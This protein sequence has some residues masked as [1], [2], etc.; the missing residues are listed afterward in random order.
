MIRN[1]LK[2]AFRN[3]MRQK[4]HAIIN[5]LGLTIGL[6]SCLLISFYV[7]DE[8]SY[9]RYHEKGERI[10]R[11]VMEGEAPTGEKAILTIGPHRLKKAFESHFN[12]I[13]EFVRITQPYQFRVQQGERLFL[14]ERIS[15][16]D[17]NIFRV[18]DFEW[19]AGNPEESLNEPFT[20]VINRST[21]EKYF[22]T[23]DVLNESLTF[24][25]DRGKVDVRVTGIIEDMPH[26]SHFHLDFLA[27]M[28]TAQYTFNARELENWGEMTV[29][30]Y[31]LLPPEISIEQIQQQTR[32]FV[33]NTFG[34]EDAQKMT[35]RYQP[36]FD[37]HL[38]SHS[39]FEFEAGGDYTNVVIFSIVAVFIL[40]IASVNYMNM[41][42]AR[43]IKRSKE[44]GIRKVAGAARRQLIFQFIGEAILLSLVAIGLAI[45]ISELIMPW[46]NQ[47]AGKQLEIQWLNR[48]WILLVIIVIPLLVGFLSGI[49]PALY[50][51]AFRPV[52]VLY[53]SGNISSS[54]SRL[55]K[56]LVTGQFAISIIL[57]I[58]TLT[59]YQQWSYMSKKKL[60]VDPSNVV[61][62]RHPGD[63][64][65]TFKQELLNNPDI[66]SVTA[67]NKRLTSRLSS[68][69]G[70]NAEGLPPDL[71]ERSIKIVTVEY[72]FFE[73]LHNEILKGRSFDKQ[74][75]E[76]EHSTFI[77]NEKAVEE[78]GWEEPIGKWFE[79]STLDPQTNNWKTRRGSVVGMAENFHFE[80]LH[81]KIA[82]VVYF[83]DHYWIGWMA[84]RISTD[85]IPQTMGAIKGVWDELEVDTYY[86]PEFYKEELNALYR[87]ERRFFRLFIIFAFLAIFIACMGIYGLASFTA[88]QRTKEMGIRKTFGASTG[89]I[90]TLVNREFLVLVAISNLIAWPVAWYS[91]RAWLENYPYRI[92]LT[93]WFFII[94][95]LLALAIAQMAVSWQAYRAASVNP[96][97]SLRY[98]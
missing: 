88:E 69:L 54:H 35:Y 70:Y 62:L 64:Y 57:I 15:L 7:I 79:T 8:L 2:I 93:P 51:S 6:T 20:T 37:I 44:V 39:R 82:P 85:N 52:R 56:I 10:Y 55:R 78:I 94:G 5:L 30:N 19:I 66:I 34:S 59:I 47:L 92:E 74:Y 21:A 1:Y 12:Q 9:D 17:K 87:S 97:Q 24:L 16:V 91:M 14:E 90:M 72:D 68:N 86:N 42:T 36:L 89:K 48:W 50:L 23:T 4:S 38:R 98:E 96:A 84:I 31:I 53:G 80:S 18:F 43:S 22:G 75:G 28:E 61:I 67:S 60:G 73:T 81:N 41:A 58:C 3:L 49:Y 76:D 77:L 32:G 27:S 46:F 26:N 13:E 63:I 11:V 95:A 29:F 25:T 65:P 33:V 71:E 45:I 40:L 83:I